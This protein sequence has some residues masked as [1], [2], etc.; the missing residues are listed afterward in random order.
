M[1]EMT[2]TKAWIAG[3]YLDSIPDNSHHGKGNGAA[4]LSSVLDSRVAEL[5]S[6]SIILNCTASY[7]EME[8]GDAFHI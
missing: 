8:T 6:Q 4:S 7:R 1:N 5:L 2:V 3:T